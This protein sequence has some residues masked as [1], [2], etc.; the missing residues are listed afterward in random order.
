MQEAIDASA[1]PAP[2]DFTAEKVFVR[3]AQEA[4]RKAYFLSSMILPAYSRW[5]T[6]YESSL[7][8]LDLARTALSIEKFR[9]QHGRLPTDLNEASKVLNIPT[10]RFT[11]SPLHFKETAHGFMVYSV[12]PDR[13]DD[14]GTEEPA[15]T[16]PG[17][18]WD[19]TFFVE[20]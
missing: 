14:D 17:A 3:K 1:K 20:R 7:T 12:G 2:L 9:L 8:A 6:K 10:D 18:R 11:G 13:A 16:K 15:I 19:I 4:E 5:I